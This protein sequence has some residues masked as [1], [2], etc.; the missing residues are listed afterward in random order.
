MTRFEKPA[1]GSK[2]RV[3]GR[4]F[5]PANIKTAFHNLPPVIS[6]E[7]IKSDG[8]DDPLSFRLATGMPHFPISVV[9][10]HSV[11]DIQYL[12]G[13]AAV[14]VEKTVAKDLVQTVSGSKGDEYVVTKSGNTYSCTCK[15]F[16]FN[17]N[18]KHVNQV[19]QLVEG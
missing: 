8:R 1:I 3:T 4:P 11:L 18:C 14:M 12:D 10:L 19:K 9:A 6:G 5:Y 17:R 2:V 13:A 15:G 7:V 16:G